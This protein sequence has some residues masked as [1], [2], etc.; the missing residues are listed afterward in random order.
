[1]AGISRPVDEWSENVH[2]TYEIHPVTASIGNPENNIKSMNRSSL[3]D[4]RRTLVIDKDINL[5]H[6]DTARPTCTERLPESSDINETLKGIGSGQIPAD[7]SGL[8]KLSSPSTSSFSTSRLLL[9]MNK[10]DI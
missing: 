6:G 2:G 7:N 1:M 10:V 5:R 8:A 3:V 9:E 4:Q